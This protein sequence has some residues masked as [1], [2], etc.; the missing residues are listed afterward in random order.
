MHTK[1]SR[2]RVAE[3]TASLG[4]GILGAGIGVLLEK[5]LGP[6]AIG[7]VALGGAMHA[8]GMWDM[9][10]M[11]KTSGFAPRPVWSLTLYWICWLALAAL[12]LY[13]LFRH[14]ILLL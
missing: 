8:F 7:L 13:A 3:V 11:E 9:R 12:G 6:M 10:R 1:T 5:Y 2:E 14:L 4:A